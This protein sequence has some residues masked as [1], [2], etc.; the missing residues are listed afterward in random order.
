MT[1]N[2]YM[3]KLYYALLKYFDNATKPIVS[4]KGGILETKNVYE[5]KEGCLRLAREFGYGLK[6][7]P[8]KERLNVAKSSYSYLCVRIYNLKPPVSNKEWIQEIMK[9]WEN[10]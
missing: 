3:E 1:A 6:D 10:K 8:K 5:G 2:E 7:Y 4:P 9:T